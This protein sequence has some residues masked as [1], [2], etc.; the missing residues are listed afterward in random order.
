MRYIGG[1]FLFAFFFLEKNATKRFFLLE[2]S[3]YSLLFFFAGLDI[4]RSLDTT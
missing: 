4:G 2:S 1:V 3:C